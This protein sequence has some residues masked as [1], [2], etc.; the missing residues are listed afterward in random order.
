[1]EN[2]GESPPIIYSL[3]V[4]CER[5]FYEHFIRIVNDNVRKKV[6]C[7]HCKKEGQELAMKRYHFDNCKKK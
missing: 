4:Y 5:V 7:P 1:M 6:V 3:V 2:S